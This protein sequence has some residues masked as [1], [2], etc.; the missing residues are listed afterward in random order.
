M[1]FSRPKKQ[2]LTKIIDD[3]GMNISDQ[4]IN[5]FLDVMQD[6]INNY[7]LVD[8]LDDFIPSE[9]KEPR[10]YHKPH[11]DENELNAWFIKTNIQREKNGLLKDKTVAIKD[12]VC[13]AE[14][15]MIN[16]SSTL[17]NYIP[18]I[19]ATIV[20]RLLNSGAKIVGKSHCECFCLSGGSHTNY[21]GPVHNPHKYGYSAGGSSSGSGALVGKGE[22][23]IA[24]GGDQ[25]GSI[26]I[27]SS[28]SG[29]YGLKPTHGLVP[30]SGIMPIETTID[31]TGPMTKNVLDNALTLEVIAGEDGLDPR[32]YNVKL[33][34]YSNYVKKGCENL[35]IGILK[36]GFNRKNSEKDVDEK[37]LNASKIFQKIGAKIEEI[38]IPWHNYGASIWAPI[39]LDGLTNQMMNG[40]GMG[41]GW[42][43][44]YCNSLIEFHSKWRERADELSDTLKI[45]MFVGQYYLS[46]HGGFYYGK[47]Q[48]L[49]RKLKNYYDDAFKS[50]DLILLPTLPLKATKLP[51]SNGS[52]KDWCSR[53]FEMIEN[54]S[55][56]DIT[57]HPAMSIPCGFSEE[58][59]IG[60]MLVAPHF[61]EDLIYQAAGAFENFKDWK[62]M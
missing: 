11:K 41:T 32:Q 14:L 27:P 2:D 28:Y 51:D 20:T 5:D 60:M 56:F 55:P 48:N 47:A 23:D 46:K 15:P 24:I 35:K 30:Y 45:C 33:K 58:L 44:L 42:K 38:S 1:N 36:E 52:L 59:P 7:E 31:H 49:A 9:R 4:K 22:V 40:N 21:T 13:I 53:A 54:T 50:Y 8:K 57:G 39:A 62:E 61:R 10:N 18:D 3:F 37:V 26:R 16:G 43:G 17:E 34:K 29:C 19:D 6:S 25:G 12:N